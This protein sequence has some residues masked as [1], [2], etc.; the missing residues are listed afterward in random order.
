MK[1][2]ASLV[3][4]VE[5]E[6]RSQR[7]RL[8]PDPVP[9][10][11]HVVGPLDPPRLGVQLPDVWLHLRPELVDVGFLVVSPGCAPVLGQGLLLQLDQSET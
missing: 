6:V 3:V 5:V 2:Q 1:L 10:A 8:V 7:P 9:A 4:L 11:D